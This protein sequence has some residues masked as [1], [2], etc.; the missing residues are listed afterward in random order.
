MTR[1]AATTG[2]EAAIE[3]GLAARP[4]GVHLPD[5]PTHGQ[6]GGMHSVEL[7]RARVSELVGNL[8][9]L[10]KLAEEHRDALSTSAVPG[11]VN[12]GGKTLKKGINDGTR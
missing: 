8:S 4:P 5:S 3:S 10:I 11:Q 12:V 7:L 9:R 1:C 2:F 6:R